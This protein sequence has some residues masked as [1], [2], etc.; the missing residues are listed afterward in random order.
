MAGGYFK[1]MILDEPVEF[2]NV[3]TGGY[4]VDVSC[5]FF[6]EKFYGEGFEHVGDVI[7][8]A[9]WNDAVL[10]KLGLGFVEHRPGAKGDQFFTMI[11]EDPDQELAGPRVKGFF[12]VVP[13]AFSS[14]ILVQKGIIGEAV[15][16]GVLV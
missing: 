9:G 6:P 1:P 3:E 15:V 5:P 4:G 2:G 14:E 10:K 11:I 12:Q 16:A 13:V 8:I 7:K